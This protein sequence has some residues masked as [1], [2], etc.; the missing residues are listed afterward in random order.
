MH[1]FGSDTE[2]FKRVKTKIMKS[3]SLSKVFRSDATILN[4]GIFE[5]LP[6]LDDFIWTKILEFLDMN[7][8]VKLS[9]TCKTLNNIC[10]DGEF[11]KRVCVSDN[12]DLGPH[13][14][15]L[16]SA[17]EDLGKFWK[18]VYVASLNCDW[19]TGQ[20]SKTAQPI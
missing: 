17:Q 12:V 11:W 3:K 4:V 19:S 5:L 8:V 1:K 7:S 9:R 15:S 16:W 6:N 20:M 13:I 10:D 2:L 14:M 18:S